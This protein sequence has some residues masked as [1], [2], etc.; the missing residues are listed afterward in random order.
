MNEVTLALI[1]THPTTTAALRSA[2]PEAPVVPDTTR[3]HRIGA[4]RVG[5]A[6]ALRR[7]ADRIVPATASS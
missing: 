4:R 2:R 6:K 3:R 1:L 7:L 5:V